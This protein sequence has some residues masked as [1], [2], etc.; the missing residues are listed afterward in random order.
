M[1][2]GTGQGEITAKDL[3][4]DRKYRIKADQEKE[5]YI[6]DIKELE[7]HPE[8]ELYRRAII[9][10]GSS[11]QRWMLVEELAELLMALVKVNRTG[12]LSPHLI[13]NLAEEI[14]DARI[15]IEQIE[16][17]YRCSPEVAKHRKAKLKRLAQ[18]IGD[19]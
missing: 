7:K 17:L 10:W 3:E 9:K 14:A 16:R 8:Q 5:L 19:L 6:K 2:G 18:R 13:D 1:G 4:E 15:M 11:A 12:A